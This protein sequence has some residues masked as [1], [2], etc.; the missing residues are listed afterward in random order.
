MN[1][2]IDIET[3]PSENTAIRESIAIG[4]L[5]PANYSKPETI[6]KW[7][8]ETKPGLVDEAMRKTAF[9][10]AEGRIFCIGFAFDEERPNVVSANRA[11][12][13]EDMLY[14]FFRLLSGRLKLAYSGGET[15]KGLKVIGHNVGWDLRF[16]L[17][18][19][20]VHSIKP[21]S[22]FCAAVAAKPWGAE[23]ADTMLLWDPSQGNK[24]SLDRLCRALKIPTPKDDMDGSKVYQE[25]KAGNL[26][27]ITAYC[28]GDVEATRNCF[29]RIT[30][31]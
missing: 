22:D 23:V 14:E 28:M 16:I 11:E 29:H 25:W 19:A 12:Q 3:L 18:R 21:P 20:I 31:K 6:A 5:P 9:D 1:L 24:I 13:E 27:K 15:T 17:K 26:D 2:T 30:F 10:G 7:E 8:A 4:I